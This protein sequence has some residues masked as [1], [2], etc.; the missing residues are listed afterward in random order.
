[1][2]ETG[3]N[4]TMA[5]LNDVLEFCSELDST[6]S[7]T[8]E[9]SCREKLIKK[10]LDLMGSKLKYTVPDFEKGEAIRVPVNLDNN[11]TP[12]INILNEI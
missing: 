11:P 6:L 9:A 7:T 1:M 8:S 12:Q 5:D 10:H 4:Y 2:F 3:R